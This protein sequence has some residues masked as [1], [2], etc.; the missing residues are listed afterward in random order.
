M[1]SFAALRARAPAKI[2]LGLFVGPTRFDGRHLLATVMQSV[3]LCDE[4]TIEPISGADGDVLVCPGVGGAP[5][6]N[7]AMR[8]LAAFREA[9]SWRE[10]PVRLTVRKRVPI[11]AG[12]GGGSADAAAALRLAAAASGHDDEGLLLELAAMLGADVPAQVR[13][14]RW[15]AEEAGERLRPLPDPAPSF[16]VL[17][18]PASEPLSTAAVYSEL[19]RVGGVRS[20]EQISRRATELMRA[21]DGGEQLPPQ[22]LLVNDLQDPALSLCPAIAGIL[23]RARAA[24]AQTAIVSGSGPTVLG[25]FGGSDGPS[26]AARAARSLT[27]DGVTALSAT[28][29]AA[30]HGEPSPV[31]QQ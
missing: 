8:A 27:V 12:L 16:G 13:P 6:E 17:L 21:L 5:E 9:T 4:L 1:S 3:S 19:D 10:G 23:E 25:L 14:G 24:G 18:L 20:A 15:L 28:P 26:R 2:N 31:T 30:A 29:V 22:E 11:A 7:L